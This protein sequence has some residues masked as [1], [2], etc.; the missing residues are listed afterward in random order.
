MFSAFTIAVGLGLLL[1]PV[2][3]ARGAKEVDASRAIPPI[4]PAGSATRTVASRSSTSLG[5]TPAIDSTPEFT[6]YLPLAVR[7][8]NPLLLYFDDFSNPD[9][10]WFSADGETGTLGY[11]DGE[12]QILLKNTDH[13]WLVTPGLATSDLVLP[14]DY[15]IEAD[16]RQASSNAGSYGLMFGIQWGGGTYEGYEVIVY[17]ATQEYLLEK[18]NGDGS[19]AVLMDWTYS[20]AIHQGMETNHLRV[21]RIGT[22]ISVYINGTLVT[23]FTDGSFTSPGRDAGVRVYSYDSAPVDVRFDNFGAYRA[24]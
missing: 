18:R 22:A 11:L 7:N 6:T 13:S 9:S 12:Y 10:G 15:R 8:Y 21:D 4:A 16:A 19:W 1:A 2:V 23:T 24:P 14:G 17:P 3:S 20:S 5:Y